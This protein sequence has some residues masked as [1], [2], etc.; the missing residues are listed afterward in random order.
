MKPS[1]VN[2]DNQAEVWQ[3]LYGNL[4][5]QKSE[6]PSFK[7]GDTVRISKWK[8]KF[9]KGYENNWS[10]E[11]FTIYKILSRIPIV[12][13]LKDFNNNVIEGTF[14][15]RE[16]QKV[17]DSGYYPVE[18]VIKKRSK[19][20]KMEYFVKFLGYPE[21]FNSWVSEVKML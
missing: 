20:G 1:S 4:S 12:Y 17:K 10:R 21:E 11:I 19:N 9:E 5:E 15:E 16:M 8:G 7:V 6:K 13:K 3:N 2:I 14:Y 18:K